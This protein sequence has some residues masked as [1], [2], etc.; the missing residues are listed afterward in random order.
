MRFTPE[1]EAIVEEIFSRHDHFTVDDLYRALRREHG[2]S[3]ASLY[4]TMPLLIAAGLVSEVFQQNGQAAYEHIY[5]HEHHCHL[6]CL[7]CGEVVEFSEPSL[8]Q[9]EERLSREHGYRISGHRLEV[10]GLCPACRASADQEP[11]DKP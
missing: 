6:L 9:L 10:R 4:R 1:R 5:G 7:K 3:R 8:D 2:V 11:T